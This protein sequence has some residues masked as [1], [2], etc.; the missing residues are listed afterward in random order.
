MW[1]AFFFFCGLQNGVMGCHASYS[2]QFFA[3]KKSCQIAADDFLGRDRALW[4]FKGHPEPS[5]LKIGCEE[6]ASA[7]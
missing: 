6:L 5:I 7:A 4:K 2:P 3:S 1:V